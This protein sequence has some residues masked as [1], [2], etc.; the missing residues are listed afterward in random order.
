MPVVIGA[1]GLA[2]DLNRGYEQRVFNQRAADLGALGAA[3]AYSSADNTS[4]LTPSARDIALANGLSGATIN[5]ELV[6]DF[7]NAGDKAVHVTVRKSVPYMLASVLGFSG[8]YDVEAEAYA[9]MGGEKPFAA[10]CFLALSSGSQAIKVSGGASISASS[11]TV[12]AIGSI[13]NT[14]GSVT[15]HD[16]ISGSG[17]VST[18]SGALNAESIRYAGEFSAPEWNSQVT[19]SKDR[20]KGETALSD[21]LANDPALASA[22]SQIGHADTVPAL[23]NPT[24][25]SG[26]DWSF[27]WSP[28]SAVAG[29]RTTPYGGEY[30]VPRGN[31]TVGR[32]EVA[33]G[34]TVRFESGSRI[35]VRNGLSI[36]GG[37]TV[38]FN[39]M[40]LYVNGGFNSGSSG[41]TIGDGAL[42]I[43]AG[44]VNFEGTNVKGDGDVTIVGTMQLGGGQHLKMGK[45]NHFFGGLK[46]SGG[47]TAWLG[48]GDFISRGGVDLSGGDS[49]L[50][51]GA[52]DIL[53]GRDSHH[54]AIKVGGGARMYMKDGKFS[55][56]GDIDTEGGSIIVFGKTANHYVNGDLRVK[57]SV[58]FG[59]GRYTVNGDFVNGTGG[60]PTWPQSTPLSGQTYGPR[61][62]DEDISGFEMVGVDV[63]FILAGTL[64]LAGG[65]KTKLI[66]PN[67]GV[68]GGQIAQLL[69]DSLTSSNTTWSGGSQSIFSGIVHLP[70]SK[71]TM[72]GGNSTLNDGH[73]FSLVADE[74]VVSGGAQTGSACAAIDDASGDDG[75]STGGIRLVR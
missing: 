40:D 63:S 9:S 10:P 58:L 42:W 72:T 56:D 53:I 12:A 5:A 2:F 6:E 33:G 43:G 39:D 47:G 45:G 16:I 18:Q 44:A 50:E 15:A 25:P 32:L 27:S 55:A 36:G 70:H 54:T 30:Y 8:S 57:G 74:I 22:R 60:S 64:N 59:A 23:T 31:Y 69:I 48:D 1:L 62:A 14:S 21:P 11:C 66:A 67:E 7:P 29:Y 35:T 41:V 46:V 51:L 3:M 68:T 52:G 17:D 65:A 37:S 20:T 73:C 28:S 61:L 71:V 26:S 13:V 34:I 24:T 75:G 38:K 4:V 19:P 49:T